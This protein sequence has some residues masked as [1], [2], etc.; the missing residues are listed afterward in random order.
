[1]QRKRFQRRI[2]I[3]LLVLLIIFAQFAIFKPIRDVGRSILNAPA[4]AADRIYSRTVS[5]VKILGDINNLSGENAVLKA[6]NDQLLAQVAS[7]S[8]VKAEN[9][10]LHKDLNFSQSHRNLDLVPAQIISFSPVSAYQAFSINKGS[11]DGLQD[12]QA[13]VSSGFLVGKVK[14]VNA[15]TSEVWLISNRNILTPVTLTGS[16]TTGILKGGIQGLVVDNIPVDA[17]VSV[18]EPVVTSALEGLYPAGIPV[19]TVADIISLKED[20]FV[21]VRLTT[22]INVGNLTTV[23]IIK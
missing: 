12:G 6:Q 19:G 23:F 5:A 20:I 18:G 7:L 15:H 11:V 1:M 14:N 10:Q 8:S 2:L 17:K 9:E 3:A 16:G 21:T 4:Y 22:P 13:V